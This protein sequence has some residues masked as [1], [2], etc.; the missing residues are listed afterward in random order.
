MGMTHP[1]NN[2]DKLQKDFCGEGEAL[3][4][5]RSHELLPVL[6]ATALAP[7]S[8]GGELSAAHNGQV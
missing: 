3:F 2:C 4:T 5:G 8:Q 7:G 1:A 6:K